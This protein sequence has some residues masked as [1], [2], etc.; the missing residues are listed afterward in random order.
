MGPDLLGG[1]VLAGRYRLIDRCGA[2]S[3]SEVYRSIDVKTGKTIA[4]R[5]LATSRASDPWYRARLRDQVGCYKRAAPH[6]VMVPVL[7][8]IERVAG[9]RTLVMTE[10]VSTPPL[11]HVL[12][13]GAVPLRA[14][15]E[16]GVQ[17]A[18]FLAHIHARDVLAPDLR[19]GAVFL[20]VSAGT[21]VRVTIDALA[22]GPLCAPDVV[23]AIQA[24]SPHM[25][26]AYLAP[27]RIRG[28]AGTSACDIYALGSLLFEMLTG[29]PMFQ[30]TP[31]EVV[32]RHLEAPPPVL[33]QTVSSMPAELEALLM[34]TFAKVPR[35]RPSAL[36]VDEELRRIIASLR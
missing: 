34:R 13:T 18:G 12:V 1:R 24:L 21:G 27:E 25:A 19:A 8:V 14:A 26:A 7:D 31:A 30:G 36:D 33:R 29:H 17:L 22:Q 4:A 35:F 32:R 6:D 11:T 16:A 2:S 20:P 5:I 15:L 28:E 10:F 9:G 23:P 3:T